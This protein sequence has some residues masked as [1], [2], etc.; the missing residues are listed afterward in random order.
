MA[1]I[2]RRFEPKAQPVSIHFPQGP[3]RLVLTLRPA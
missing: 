3:G 2:L 1:A